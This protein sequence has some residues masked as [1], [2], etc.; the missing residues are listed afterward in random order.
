M[1][2]SGLVDGNPKSDPDFLLK[3]APPP[4]PPVDD[5]PEPK[6]MLPSN[7][8][9]ADARPA[10]A[11]PQPAGGQITVRRMDA[12][13]PITES[14]SPPPQ[15]AVAPPYA[16]PAVPP[17]APPQAAIAPPYVP[18]PTPPA[19]P[20][21]PAPHFAAISPPSGPG[22]EI[23]VH[24]VAPRS[25]NDA[26]LVADRFKAGTPVVLDMQTVESDLAKR[27]IGFASG[28]TYGLDGGMERLDG[29]VFLLIPPGVEIP[30]GQRARLAAQGSLARA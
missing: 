27:L 21:R 28:L 4:P 7:W 24:R 15:A 17:P 12:P 10:E 26:Q 5:A 23:S 19:P 29:R 9:P 25:F 18:P 13:A 22:G 2:L 1:V 11:R 6:L 8:A 14:Y 16:P 3:L 20:P 30:A